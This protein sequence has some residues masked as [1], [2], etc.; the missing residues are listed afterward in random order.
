MAIRLLLW[1]KNLNSDKD[2]V[3]NEK[4]SKWNTKAEP[5]RLNNENIQ[6]KN[7]CETGETIA[8]SWL[9]SKRSDSVAWYHRYIDPKHQKNKKTDS[10]TNITET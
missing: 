8:D 1:K 2:V 7:V 10:P 4:T 6:K 5:K 9:L 3:A